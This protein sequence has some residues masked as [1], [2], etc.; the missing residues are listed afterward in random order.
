[1][2]VRRAAPDEGAARRDSSFLWTCYNE[3]MPH[4]CMRQGG[5]M[6]AIKTVGASGQISLGKEYAGQTVM[7]EELEQGTWVV[8]LG[9]FVPH[10][11]RWLHEPKASALLDR[12]IAWAEIN[13]PSE[14]SLDELAERLA[15]R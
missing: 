9:E 1:M 8:K 7:V 12:A 10:S 14:T 5:N 13:P 3:I 11:E 6:A 2:R 4:V 15:Q